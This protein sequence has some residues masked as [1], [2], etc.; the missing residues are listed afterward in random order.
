MDN[1]YKK[2][3]LVILVIFFYT[4]LYI[5]VIQ[6]YNSIRFV[7]KVKNDDKNAYTLSTKSDINK[8]FIKKDKST[9]SEILEGSD[10]D[11]EYFYYE[12]EAPYIV[13]E[14]IKKNKDYYLDTMPE[15]QKVSYN[16]FI[17]SIK[18]EENFQDKN[19]GW[20]SLKN[21]NDKL[22]IGCSTAVWC[23][24]TIKDSELEKYGY[25]II[26]LGGAFDSD[27]TIFLKNLQKKQYKKI[28]IFGGVNDV[29]LR[30]FTGEKIVD[31]N[32]ATEIG[33][34]VDESR[35]HLS[36]GVTDVIFVRVKPMIYG[37]DSEDYGF[38]NRFNNCA[39]QYNDLLTYLIGVK[40][41][42][43]PFDTSEKYSAGYVHYNKLEVYKKIFDDINKLE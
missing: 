15:F 17:E 4:L 25:D 18:N 33:E 9:N 3:I 26:G 20:I 2:N 30:A 7:D 40:Y 41:Y 12:T 14:R 24:Y 13:A 34:L 42:D 16:N 31:Y 23:G 36:N 10:F 27:L 6:K 21:T 8:P 22:I 43:I 35:N 11:S 29:N 1:N 39:L 37:E 28:L 5:L 38:V 32:F 19:S